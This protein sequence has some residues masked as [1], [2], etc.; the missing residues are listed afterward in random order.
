MCHTIMRD[1]PDDFP[2]TQEAAEEKRPRGRPPGSTIPPDQRKTE[3]LRCRTTTAQI[4]AYEK[5]GGEDWLR[6]ELDRA[7]KRFARQPK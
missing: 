5:L 4:Q 6:G 3:M 7:I 1:M 2:T